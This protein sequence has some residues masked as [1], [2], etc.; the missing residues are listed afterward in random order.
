MKIEYNNKCY[1]FNKQQSLE[2][3]LSK[4]E[5]INLPLE[6]WKQILLVKTGSVNFDVLK[7][8]LL[9]K[10]KH[11]DK[12]TN[13]NS[14]EYCKN[15]YWFDKNTRLSLVNL[16]NSTSE[17][18]QIFLVDKFIEIKPEELKKFL[19]QLEVYA[20]KCYVNTQLHLLNASK[21]ELVEDL[22]NYDYTIGYP[23]KIILNE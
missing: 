5:L 16:A 20:S 12:S 11:Y 18:V 1:Y 13:V 10:I 6:A 7:T 22:I 15:L 14:F 8:V 23:D 17:S 19:A 21:L 3:L 9:Q 2:N 4:G